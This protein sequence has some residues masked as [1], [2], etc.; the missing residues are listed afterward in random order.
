MRTRISLWLFAVVIFGLQLTASA[1]TE[2]RKLSAFTEISLRI[3]AKLYVRQGDVQKVTIDAKASVLKEIITEISDRALVIR[4]PAK[5]YF[6]RNPDFGSIVIYITVPE[7]TGLNLSGSGDIDAGNTLSSLIMDVNISGSGN[8]NL[9]DL[10]AERVKAV[11]SGSGN[12]I[13]KGSK[14]AAEFTGTISGSG[15]IKAQQLEADEVKVTI[16]GSGNCS[17]RSNGHCS[18]RI[19]G[20]GSFFYSG[21]PDV[22]STVAGSG[23]VKENN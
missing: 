7:I 19:A 23:R 21:N 4:F 5:N 8:I 9:S 2:E 1:E 11:I 22:D 16:S 17:I 12:I 18:V 14:V 6:L 15:N 10:K 20:S 3:P 13:L